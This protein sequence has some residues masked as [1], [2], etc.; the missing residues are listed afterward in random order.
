M[1]KIRSDNTTPEI[2]FR[3]ALWAK[4]LRY[5]KNYSK[6]PGKPDIV[7]TKQKVTVFIDGEFWHGFNWHEKK[8]KIKTN[9]E[10]WIKKIEG[11][12]TRDKK[13]VQMLEDDGWAILR[14]WESE[15][16]KE[17]MECLEKVLA[18]LNS[19]G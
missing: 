2:I 5:R 7:F 11:N 4:G 12:M 9:S 18:L 3:K 17:L 19:R 6:L 13:N 10:Y 14:F 15:I 8:G 16:R 1:S